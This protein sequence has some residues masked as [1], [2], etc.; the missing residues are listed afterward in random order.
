MTGSQTSTGGRPSGLR[1]RGS[2]CWGLLLACLLVACDGASGPKPIAA[3]VS[4][5]E[6]LSKPIGSYLILDVRTPAEYAAGH[7]DNA[8]N[9]SH[10]QLEK[11]LPRLQKYA[12]APVLLYCKSGG[13]AAKAAETLSK[14]GF[15]NLNHLTGDYEGWVAAG[16]PVVENGP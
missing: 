6:F 11:Q 12:A 1:A 15:T 9:V 7:L 14:A 8:L 10:D 16:Y 5:A 2:R 3:D 4:H 13:R